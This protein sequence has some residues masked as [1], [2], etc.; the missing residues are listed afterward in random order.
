MFVSCGPLKHPVISD[1]GDPK[2]VSM[3]GDNVQIRTTVEF[4]NGEETGGKIV[5]DNVEV[6]VAGSSIGKVE[7]QEISVPVNQKFYVPLTAVVPYSKLQENIVSGILN[8]A[9]YKNVDV[10]FRGNISY[11]KL[12]E[13]KKTYH[14]DKVQKIN[15]NNVLR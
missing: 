15:L 2:V 8:S 3:N 6:F 10:V 9:L 1:M 5:T 12:G 4:W 11:Q 13:V 14:I 7:L